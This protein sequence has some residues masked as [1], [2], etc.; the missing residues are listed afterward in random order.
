MCWQALEAI[1]TVGATIGTIFVA[2]CAIGGDY[3]RRRWAAPQ[4]SLSLRNPKGD[5]FPRGGAAPGLYFHLRLN[6][7]RDW[8]PA[9]DV[10]VLVERVA[11]RTTGS[12]FVLEPLVYPLPLAW[13]TD[14]GVRLELM[15]GLDLKEAAVCM[16]A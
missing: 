1:A 9:S 3:F 16:R 4:L 15:A 7:N 8:S 12:S 6:N 2:I 14:H 10:R 11:R 5:T 13:I